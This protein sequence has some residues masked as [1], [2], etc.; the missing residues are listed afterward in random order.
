MI[1]K[2]FT[3]CCKILPA[4]FEESLSYYEVLCKVRDKLN[5]TIDSVNSE[6]EHIGELETE[7]NDIKAAVPQLAGWIEYYTDTYPAV[8]VTIHNDIVATG[9]HKFVRPYQIG[10]IWGQAISMFNYTMNTALPYT[11]KYNLVFTDE[12][13]KTWSVKFDY[14]N[15]EY[16][17]VTITEVT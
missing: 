13:D 14:D 10:V 12:N 15:G 17:N 9:I 16:S 7:I 6:E 1:Q 5:E 8:T 11:N 4:V 2:L 3:K